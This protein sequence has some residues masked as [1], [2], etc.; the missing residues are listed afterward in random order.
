MGKIFREPDC[1]IAPNI[2]LMT[3]WLTEYFDEKYA[4]LV[5]SVLTVNIQT[6]VS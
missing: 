6:D 4:D 1:N 2:A 5:N 3:L